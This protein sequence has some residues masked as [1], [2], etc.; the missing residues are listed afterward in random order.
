M[1]TKLD[2]TSLQNALEQ[3]TESLEYLHSDLAQDAKLYRQFRAA[4]IQAFEYSYEL[5]HKSLR[6]FLQLNSPSAQIIEEMTFS[7]LIRKDMSKDY[8]NIHG[9]HG[10]YIVMHAT[11][12][13]MVTP[14]I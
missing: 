2:F 13:A 5:S 8:C 12:Q 1:N 11:A 10:G 4:S 14:R 6:R 3:L 9:H 7:Q